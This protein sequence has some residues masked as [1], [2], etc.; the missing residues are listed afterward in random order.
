MSALPPMD[1]TLTVNFT[2]QHASA[3][4]AGHFPRQVVVPGAA[5]LDRVILEVEGAMH[6]RV[7]AVKQVKFLNAALPDDAFA[8]RATVTGA[9]VR[10]DL[11]S[12]TRTVCT[13]SLAL[14]PE[15]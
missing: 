6:E 14:G 10:F 1:Q 12:G 4:F 8:L 3:R 11:T 13:G 5:L 9:T 15:A 7:L 2:C